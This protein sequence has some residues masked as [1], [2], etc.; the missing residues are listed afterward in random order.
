KGQSIQAVQ[1]DNGTVYYYQIPDECYLEGASVKVYVITEGT[2]IVTEI[3]FLKYDNI[4]AHGNAGYFETGHKIYKAV[5]QPPDN[6]I[7]SYLRDLI[8]GECVYN[9]TIG[10]LLTREINGK[11]Y[12]YRMCDDPDRDG[13]DFDLDQE[14]EDMSF[15]SIHKGR[16]LFVGCRDVLLQPS[17]I[18]FD[19]KTLMIEIPYEH[20]I[21]HSSV[22]ASD[23]SPLIYIFN[24]IDLFTMNTDSRLFL[25]ALQFETDSDDLSIVGV[26]NGVIT[27]TTTDES[28]IDV[29]YEAQLPNE[30]AG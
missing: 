18:K 19:D 27:M 4:N 26:H 8:Q 25:P 30:F 24:G 16:L 28:G 23:E 3:P 10:A 29:F 11:E 2:Q 17:L 6:L 20:S 14:T 21:D 12:I 1:A 22:F 15:K 7:A 5:F 9:E 13:I